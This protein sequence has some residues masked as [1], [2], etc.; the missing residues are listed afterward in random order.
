MALTFSTRLTRLDLTDCKGMTD[1]A[2]RCVAYKD[3]QRM[4]RSPEGG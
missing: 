4:K 3:I 1:E 2:V